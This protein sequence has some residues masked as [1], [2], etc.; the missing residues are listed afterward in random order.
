VVDFS[1]TQF[2]VFLSAAVILALTPGP[3]I[4]YVIARTASG[5]TGDGVASTAGTAV[6]GLVHVAGAALGL[7]LI[8]SQSAFLFSI[9]RYAGPCYL[10]YLGVRILLTRTS[11]DFSPDIR[12]VGRF[13]VFWEGAAVE[14]FNVKTALF[15]LAF[16]P[17]FINLDLPLPGQFIAYG[18]ICVALNSTVDL[19]VVFGSLLRLNKLKSAK[20]LNIAS[21]AILI[22]LGAYVALAGN[23]R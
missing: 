8:I 23:E 22:G 21:G 1:S 13:R 19:L 17:Q 11:T 2:W 9:L 7:S 10:I 14:A 4:T 20:P 3:G 5:G 18:V 16:I 12:Q 15:F 6:G